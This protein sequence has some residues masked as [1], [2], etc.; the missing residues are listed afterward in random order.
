MGRNSHW[1]ITVWTQYLAV[2]V[3]V[4][5]V[6]HLVE[7]LLQLV[8]R[9]LAQEVEQ[10]RAVRVLRQ[11]VVVHPEHLQRAPRIEI[12]AHSRTLRTLLDRCSASCVNGAW[13]KFVWIEGKIRRYQEGNNQVAKRP[14]LQDTEWLSVFQRLSTVDAM[15]EV[16]QTSMRKPH[17]SNSPHCMQQA[18]DHGCSTHQNQTWLHF[19]ALCGA[20]CRALLPVWIGPVPPW[21]IRKHAPRASTCVWA[22]SPRRWSRA[23]TAARPGWRGC[24]RAGWTGSATWPASAA[25]S[26]SPRGTRPS[27]RA[28]SAPPPAWTHS[29]TPCKKKDVMAKE[30]RQTALLL[31]ST[32]RTATSKWNWRSAPHE[33]CRLKVEWSFLLATQSCWQN[34]KFLP[35]FLDI[36][37]SVWKVQVFQNAWEA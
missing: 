31:N 10:P 34:S 14:K 5:E 32:G 11:P 19:F 24:S 6:E 20:L 21:R 33:T 2:T 29:R 25:G 12:V 23:R 36:P 37:G 22:P 15:R 35:R 17:C 27:C 4:E 28:R 30:F 18:R 13:S 1:I 9:H 7:V 8:L 26:P 16:E 3:G